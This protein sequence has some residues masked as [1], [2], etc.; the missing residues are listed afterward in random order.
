M[1]VACLYIPPRCCLF[2]CVGLLLKP[3]MVGFSFCYNC[4]CFLSVTG[5]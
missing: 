5:A 1:Y 3:S 2:V 4:V